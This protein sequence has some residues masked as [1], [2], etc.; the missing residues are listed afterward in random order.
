MRA[1]NRERLLCEPT[2]S[3]LAGSA[4]WGNSIHSSEGRLALTENGRTS[5]APRRRDDATTTAG[6]I[7]G[8]VKIP[9]TILGVAKEDGL[10]NRRAKSAS[11][12]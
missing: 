11:R 5:E 4:S 3:A 6:E 2:R 7:D 9:A 1:G 12:S 10:R 8:D